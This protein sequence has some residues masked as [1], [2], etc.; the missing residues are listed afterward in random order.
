MVKKLPLR[1]V[2]ASSFEFHCGRHWRWPE[3]ILGLLLKMLP[4]EKSVNL[5][6]VVRRASCERRWCLKVQIMLHGPSCFKREEWAEGESLNFNHTDD[7][8][9]RNCVQFVNIF[10]FRSLFYLSYTLHWCYQFRRRW[11]RNVMKR[12]F[13]VIFC[14][15]AICQVTLGTFLCQILNIILLQLI[16]ICCVYLIILSL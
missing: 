12:L 2:P 14:S 9:F 13:N 16:Q 11:T 10:I 5:A 7:D 8:S 4:L 3:G 15:F 1:G 6:F